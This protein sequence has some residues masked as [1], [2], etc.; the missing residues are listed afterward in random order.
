MTKLPFVSVVVCTYNRSLQLEECINTLRKLNYPKSRYEIIIVDDGSKEQKDWIKS[1]DVKLVLHPQ[2][3]GIPKARNTGYKSSRGEIVAFID[4]DCLADRQWLKELIKP[5]TNPNVIGVGGIVKPVSQKNLTEKFIHAM[6]YGNPAPIEFGH[7]KN[8]IRRF[9]VY[10][11]DMQKPI[12]TNNKV[13]PVQSIYLANASFRKRALIAVGGF[14][15][16]LK[17]SEDT[18]LSTRL[19]QKFSSQQIV[20]NNIAIV[21]HRHHTSFMNMLKQT[22][23]RSESTL[24]F[25]IKHHLF[26]PIFPFPI[27]IFFSCLLLSLWNVWYAL[28]GYIFFI[29]ILYFW[30]PLRSLRKRDASYILFSYMQF[31]SELVSIL[32]LLRGF[33][34]YLV[35]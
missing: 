33:I 18:D 9:F 34:I 16:L 20:F 32:G 30:W 28:V 21:L 31:S 35:K 15:E 24:R 12:I 6:N 4:D 23:F 7:S 14:D 11:K 10:L 13:I 1:P 5:Y 17:S 29:P 25:Y 27:L 8:P 22:F 19:R 26:P 3:L 2:N